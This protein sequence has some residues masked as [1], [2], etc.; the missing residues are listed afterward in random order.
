LTVEGFRG[1]NKPVRLEFGPKATV[2]SAFNGRGKSTLLGAIE[3]GLFGE[4]KFQP[5]ENRTRDELVSLFH[6]GGKASVQLVLSSN[7]EEVRIRRT[8]SVGKMG[9]SV[10]VSGGSRSLEAEEAQA[11]LF[12]LT[13]LDFRDFYRAAFLHQ[14]S[15]RGL[16]TEEQKDRDEALDR[17]LGVETI[18]NIL[19]AIPLKP[20]VNAIEEIEDSERRIMDRLSGAGGMAETT[21]K[22]A[23]EEAV[24]SGYAEEDL[25][26]ETGQRE[27][28]LLQ[29]DLGEAC[30][31]FGGEKQ[32]PLQVE[33]PEDIERVARRI[34]SVTKDIRYSA[35]KETPLD[36]AVSQLGVL[37]KLRGELESANEALRVAK[38]ELQN[39]VA[40][41]GTTE[42]W[43]TRESE[44]EENAATAEA[45]LH[46]LDAHGRVVEDALAYFEAVPKAKECP[47]CGDAKEAS[48]LVARLK[49]VVQ[50]DQAAEIRRLNKLKENAAESL[51][52]LKDLRKA[53]D[54]LEKALESTG[55]ELESEVS[56]AWRALGAKPGR[57]GPLAVIDAQE[58][59]INGR[60]EGLR[61]LNKEREEALQKLDEGADRVRALMRF[62]KAEADATRVREKA[63]ESE[64]GGAK[65][66]EEDKRRL[67][68]LKIDLDSIIQALNGLAT[69]RAQTAL[70]NCGPDIARIYGQLCN[71]PY[72]DGLKI[73]VGQKAVSG[74]QRNTYRLIAFSTKD[75]EK[76]SASSRLSTAQMNCVALSVYLSLAQVLSHNLGFVMLDDPSQ[77]LDADHKSALASV[78]RDL[79][80]SSQLVVGTHDAEFDGYLKSA[81]GNQGVSWYD[82]RWAPRDGTTLKQAT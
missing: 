27:S 16:L 49:S 30:S 43:R 39:H 65:A 56:R 66:F 44:A 15:I 81:L 55:K 34:K 54:K 77:N 18:R 33:T 51:S 37:K 50:K 82:L 78:L 23:L 9:S 36:S 35:G 70:A 7:S 29:N 1:V 61:N 2:L 45:A 59:E 42:E 26:L 31:K 71:H 25:T 8:K 46:I 6:P 47:V 28:K 67:E 40:S 14:D 68:A 21:R 52:E 63:E 20:V 19:T 62:L 5:P 17:L 80:P 69:G 41:V 3:W 64:G 75:G 53:R 10:E 60:L 76:T 22:R 72:F 11:Y 13:G 79:L 12:R 24:E 48:K 58:K 57:G 32:D 4:L 73:E 38:E 74:V